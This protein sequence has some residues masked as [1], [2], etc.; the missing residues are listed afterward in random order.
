MNHGP[1]KSSSSLRKGNNCS[2]QLLCS[3][4]LV[5]PSNCFLPHS[6]SQYNNTA[7][8]LSLLMTFGLSRSLLKH[9]SQIGNHAADGANGT[10]LRE[11]CGTVT[12]LTP[13]TKFLFATLTCFRELVSRFFIHS[14]LWALQSINFSICS[15]LQIHR[16]IFT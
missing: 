14:E 2:Q 9:E 4:Q 7:S 5:L 6:F 11:Y 3:A 8:S 15:P 16:V 12:F 13:D 10:Q 1:F